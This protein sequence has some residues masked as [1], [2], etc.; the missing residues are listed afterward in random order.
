M[1]VVRVE[2]K[3]RLGPIVLLV[4]AL[5]PHRVVERPIQCQVHIQGTDVVA[6]HVVEEA[7]TLGTGD[8]IRRGVEPGPDAV[9]QMSQC[10]CSYLLQ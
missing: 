1:L 2:G 7:D 3:L 4:S 6:V 5:A 8:G 9:V 10:T